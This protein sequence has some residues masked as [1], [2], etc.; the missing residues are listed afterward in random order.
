MRKASKE[1]TNSIG[2]V[3]YGPGASWAL[4]MSARLTEEVGAVVTYYGAQSIPMDGA[5]A[6]YLSHWAETDS[7]V[8]DLE[9]AELGLNLQMAGLDFRF[10]HHG[11]TSNGFAEQGRPEY[12][13]EAE[14]VA[15]RQTTEFLAGHL[16]V[17]D[18][19]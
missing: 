6:P 13:P 2:I 4:W 11:G 17:T 12:N 7:L 9:V 19:T 14:A 3:G 1:P 8:S 5:S 10:E 16:R 18:E 15:W